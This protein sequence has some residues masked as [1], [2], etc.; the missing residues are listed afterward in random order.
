MGLLF[1]VGAVGGLS[2]YSWRESF[3]WNQKEYF[4]KFKEEWVNI[5][6]LAAFV[7]I[8]TRL[9][10]VRNATFEASEYF[11]IP[12]AILAFVLTFSAWTDGWSGYAPQEIAWLGISMSIPIMLAYCLSTPT[13]WVGL[14]NVAV[15]GVVCSILWF[16]RGLGGADTRL[17]WLIN[18]TTVWWVGLYWSVV[19]FGIA[20]LIQI[21]I[22]ILA[23]KF[24]W[25]TIRTTKYSKSERFFRKAFAKYI[26]SIDPD[27]IERPRRHV[28]FIPVLAIVWIVGIVYLLAFRLELLLVN[29]LSFY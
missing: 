1:T 28:Q 12:L 4:A 18:V 22:H 27:K 19:I 2:L 14:V 21:V 20:S 8:L 29:S 10:V 5:I 9:L 23:Q 6:A 16:Q 7:A 13:G 25:G 15:W 17:L 11:L 3:F 26:K 24:N